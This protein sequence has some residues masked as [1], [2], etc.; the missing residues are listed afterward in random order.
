MCYAIPGRLI[1]KE[2]K[3]G[4]IDYFGEHKRALLGIVDAEEGDY[5]Y[6]QGGMLIRKVPPEAAIET[7]KAWEELFFELKEIDKDLA[8]K[9]TK[10][11]QGR[12]AFLEIMEKVNRGAELEK[13]DVKTILKAQD[14]DELDLL[15]NTA[16][17]VRH[18]EHD[19]S[20]CV[21]GI[22]EFS[23]CCERSCLYCGIRKESAVKRYRMS[24]GEIVDAVRYAVEKLNFKALVLQSGED[25]WYTDERLAE[26]VEKINQ[27]GVL[28]FLSIG[29]RSVELYK[30][31]FD[32]GA[33]AALLRFETSNKDIFEK[34]RPSRKL[35][36]RL[37]LI[38]FLKELG[39]IVATGFLAGL[40]GETVDDVV[41]NI[42]LTKELGAD[43]YSF[44]P[45]IP[46]N[47]TPLENYTPM[48]SRDVLKITAASRMVDRKAKLVVSTSFETLD[49]AARKDALLAGAN[50][51]MINVTPEAY[52][53][54][55]RI[56]DGRNYSYRP[57][58]EIKKVTDLLF[59]LGRAPVDLGA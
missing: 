47:G 37:E 9:R 21:H 11:K 16:N 53:S 57:Q 36:E 34:L 26:I 18:K 49:K 5:V 17:N 48:N 41:N 10:I 31:L 22:I 20:S 52:R 29:E 19:N 59:S 23:N 14:K 35:E 50:S 2:A 33:K 15:F 30:R 7:L 54:L 42:F 1:K 24:E 46:A 27:L 8:N 51:L 43:M 58:D 3:V 13:N 25:M 28:M 32:S 45:F 12:S 55:Y 40:P 44:G 4:I 38:K 6:A 56:Y 39:Y